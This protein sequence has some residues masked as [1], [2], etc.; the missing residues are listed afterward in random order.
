MLAKLLS[1]LD[2]YLP[3]IIIEINVAEN[4]ITDVIIYVK[5]I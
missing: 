1:E 5:S 4:T 2:N 3:I